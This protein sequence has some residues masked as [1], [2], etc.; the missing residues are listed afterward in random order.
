MYKSIKE[1]N[2]S[3]L[4]IYQQQNQVS[5][6]VYNYSILYYFN[7]K[8]NK[9]SIGILIFK[10][11]INSKTR[12]GEF[13]YSNLDWIIIMNLINMF[14]LLK[15]HRMLNK[16][17]VFCFTRIRS[18]IINAKPSTWPSPTQP[19]FFYNNK[20]TAFS[21]LTNQIRAWRR[22]ESRDLVHR[23]LDEPQHGDHWRRLQICSN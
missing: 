1:I 19:L 20:T 3:N 11:I 6:H 16:I 13:K 8:P 5:L 4:S 15:D 12:S 17:Q 21:S 22:F 10:L 7:I 18:W 14:V 23:K 2:Q 9:S